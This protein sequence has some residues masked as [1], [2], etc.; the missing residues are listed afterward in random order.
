MLS[1]LVLF[2]Y[3]TVQDTF[4]L[5]NTH[6]H[7]HTHTHITP[8]CHEAVVGGTHPVTRDESIQLAALQCQVLFGDFKEERFEKKSFLKPM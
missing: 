8:K 5:Y 3:M 7:T 2:K 6:T 1:T 4:S